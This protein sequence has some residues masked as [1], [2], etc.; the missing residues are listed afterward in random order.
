M[1]NQLFNSN[2]DAFLA[3]FDLGISEVSKNGWLLLR[4]G[5]TTCP[6]KPQ[7]QPLGI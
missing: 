2:V 5:L 1:L 7:S 6:V 3:E 4:V